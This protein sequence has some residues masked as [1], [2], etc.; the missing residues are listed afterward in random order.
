MNKQ[1]KDKKITISVRFSPDT[2]RTL[3]DVSYD[4]DFNPS[5]IIE[6]GTRKFLV[7]IMAKDLRGKTRLSGGAV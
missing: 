3:A 7:E 5:Y 2:I 6:E 1:K 4:H